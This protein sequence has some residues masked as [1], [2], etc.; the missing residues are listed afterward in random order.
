MTDHD[1][2][3]FQ[4]ISTMRNPPPDHVRRAIGTFL[5]ACQTEARPFAISQALGAVRRVFP[6]LDI[7]DA[8]LV[9]AITREALA[10]GFDVKY[11]RK[12]TDVMSAVAVLNEKSGP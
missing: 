4:G 1:E 7:S 8:D 6:D 9:S 2:N 11:G 10:A 5:A 12:K 3:P